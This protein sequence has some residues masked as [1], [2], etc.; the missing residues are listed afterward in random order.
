M[1][2]RPLRPL[3]GIIGARSRGEDPARIEAHRKAERLHAERAQE[4]RRAQWRLTLMGAFFVCAFGTATARMAVV[5][6]SDPEEPSS[7]STSVPVSAD[8]A[9]IVDR[10]GRVLATNL[11][12]W[13][14][15]VQP[16]LMVDPHTAAVGLAQVFPDLDAA[17]TE[18]RIRSGRFFWVKQSISPEERQRVHDIGEPGL[19]FAPRETRLYPAGRSVAHIIGA[20]SFGQLEVYAAELVGTAGVERWFDARLRD[21]AKVGVP[22]ELSIDLA[23]QVAMHDVL[24][25]AMERYTAKGAAGIVMDVHTGEIIS[26]VSLPDFDPNHRPQDP[27]DPRLFNRAAQGV[28]ELGSTFKV[29]NAAL[30]ME[31]GIARPDTMVNTSGPLLWGRFKI[32]DMHNMPKQLSL[33]DVL[34]HSSNTGSARLAVMAGTKAQQDL[35]K[36]LGFF[37]P[38]SIQ[39]GEAA[40]AKPLLPGRWSELSTM[41]ISYGHGLAA[42]PLHLAAAYATLTNGGLKVN[43]TLLHD[44]ETPTEADRVVS[45]E[46]SLHLREMMR[47]VVERGT[48]KNAAVPGYLIGGKTGTAD[49]PQPTGGYAHNKVM[50]TFAAVFPTSAPKYVVIVTLDEASTQAYGRTWRTAG[51]TAAPTMANAI[52]RIAP[53]LGMRPLPKTGPQEAPP[54]L[55]VRN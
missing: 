41:T 22:L 13:A 18:E 12:T 20:A 36:R 5:A 10:R 15:Y 6:N 50:A 4:R 52:R 44:P 26:M 17:K 3:A 32:S 45:A 35:L 39:L 48:G 9:D 54:P 28:Y 46:T 8:R 34:V 51:W 53:V 49:K 31:K 42:T 38:T 21:P 27:S 47:A 11:P 37:E 43:P 29:I 55:L 19:Q 14:L 24:E 25:D 1:T 40:Q 33:T 2:R 23:A 7:V 16:N 30:A